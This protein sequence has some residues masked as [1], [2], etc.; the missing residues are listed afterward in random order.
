MNYYDSYSA[1]VIQPLAKRVWNRKN[2]KDQLNRMLELIDIASLCAFPKIDKPSEAYDYAPVKL[3]AFPEFFLQGWTSKADLKKY[4]EDILIEIPGEET[5][6]IGERAKAT[7]SYICGAALEYDEDWPDRF[8]SC[9]FIV[10]PEGKVIHKYHKFNCWL[11]GDCETSPHDMFDMYLEKYGKGKSILETFF[12]VADTRCGKIGTYICFDSTFPETTRALALN[13]A[14]ILVYMTGWPTPWWE[15]FEIM[16]RMRAIENCAYVVAANNGGYVDPN[17][18][19]YTGTE[20]LTTNWW[21][22]NSMI[23]DYRGVIQ[24]KAPHHGESIVTAPIYLKELRKR[25]MDYS[26]NNLL[27][28]RSEV[29]REM[30]KDP[31]YPKN[32]FLKDPPQSIKDLHRRAPIEVLEKFLKKGT[33]TK[34]E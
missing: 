6:K 24:A 23:V 17:R 18:P 14:E 15:Y 25:R 30:Y 33:F 29:W 31:I 28:L 19:G 22:G 8:L 27:V 16:N 20:E 32:K 11:Y 34:P 13:G 10:G 2:L 9:G 5:D 21:H 7:G 4:K 12:P 26:W 3:M 1:A